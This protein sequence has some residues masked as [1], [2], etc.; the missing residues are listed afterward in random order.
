MCLG[1]EEFQTVVISFCLLTSQMEFG[2]PSVISL[3]YQSHTC[4]T[5]FQN[6]VRL[7]FPVNGS[8]GSG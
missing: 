8:Q 4:F 6:G 3:Q 1:H 5:L 7:E 2:A